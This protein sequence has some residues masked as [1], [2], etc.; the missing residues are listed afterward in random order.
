MSQMGYKTFKNNNELLAA[1]SVLKRCV[2]VWQAGRFSDLGEKCD[3][4][5]RMNE[6]QHIDGHL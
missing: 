2:Y 1:K 4:S 3:L 6:E 5:K